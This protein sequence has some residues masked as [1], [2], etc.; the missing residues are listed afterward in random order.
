MLL[1]EYLPVLMSVILIL[2][3]KLKTNKRPGYHLG[4]I[5]VL[6]LL[7]MPFKGNFFEKTTFYHSF[8]TN[9]VNAYSSKKPIFGFKKAYVQNII[10]LI[11]STANLP[12]LPD[13]VKNHVFFPKKIRS[14]SRNATIS[15]AFYIKFLFC[16]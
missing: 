2:N 16:C 15:V 1:K 6:T 7:I 5:Y 14:Y 9:F 13:L 11:H 4:I 8:Y 3:A 12:R 10:I